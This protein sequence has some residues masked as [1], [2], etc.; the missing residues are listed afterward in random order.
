MGKD[1]KQLLLATTN[2]WW[3][4]EVSAEELYHARVATIYKKGE[5]SRAENYSPISLLGGFY[6]IYMILIRK[7]IQEEVEDI[8]SQ[9]QYGFRPAKSTA[10]AIY[11]IRRI[12]DYAEKRA[13][14]YT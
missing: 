3:E 7:R 13:D 11:I 12:Q 6:K 9:A 1:N 10:H 2:Q 4:T 14:H 5:T 8:V